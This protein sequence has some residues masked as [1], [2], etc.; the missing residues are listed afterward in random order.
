MWEDLREFFLRLWLRPQEIA[1]ERRVEKERTRFW[2]ELHE[3][4]QEAEDDAGP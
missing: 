4:E 2:E 1:E 3:G